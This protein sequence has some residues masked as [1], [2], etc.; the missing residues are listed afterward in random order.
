MRQHHL[1]TLCRF[2]VDQGL[3]IEFISLQPST[4]EVE[5]FA[6]EVPGLCTHHLDAWSGK[7]AGRF[8]ENGLA[9]RRLLRKLHF[10]I[11]YIIDS[12]T[13]P[14]V[15]FATL[16]TMHW[17]KLPMVYHTFDM[18]VPNVAPR[19][20]LALERHTARRSNLNINTDRSRAE[21]TKALFRLH[22]TPLSVPLRLPRY[23]SLPTPDKHLRESLLSFHGDLETFLVVSPTGLSRERNGKE[24]I[25]AMAVLPREYHLVTIDEVGDY[26]RECRDMSERL[27]IQDRVHILSPMSHDKLLK[28][29]ACADVGLI[30]YNVEESLGN[31]LC[32]PSRLAY[33]VGLGLPVV[34]T[35]VPV[36]EAV[37]YRHGL[38]VCCSS[39]QPES[40]AEAIQEICAGSVH[41]PERK[42]HIRQIFE[43]ELYYERF[44]TRIVDALRGIR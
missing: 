25:Q 35:D 44:A 6:G 41:L 43:R 24:I 1:T 16:G 20:Y 11:L 17:K 10:N 5:W 12:W 22:E 18:L 31:F 2:L 39:T 27:G 37:I 30:F 21:V 15:A 42:K 3:R 9:L 40:I 29:C 38:G 28:I 7:K 26:G 33:F 32:H 8:I 36:L 19:S 4:D 14:Y 23:A 13:L 34:A